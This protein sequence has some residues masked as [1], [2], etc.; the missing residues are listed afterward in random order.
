MQQTLESKNERRKRLMALPYPEKV[1]LVEKLRAAAATM[2]S[3]A[4]HASILRQE[5]PDYGVKRP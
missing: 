2:R 4:R 5:A 3:A 1:R